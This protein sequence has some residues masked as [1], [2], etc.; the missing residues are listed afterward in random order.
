MGAAFRWRPPIQNFPAESLLVTVMKVPLIAFLH[1]HCG[2]SLQLGTRGGV[3]EKNFENGFEFLRAPEV[4]TTDDG[5]SDSD[6]GA[7]Y[8]VFACTLR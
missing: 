6:D 3:G 1:V 2:R 8:C 5:G 4:A 7:T